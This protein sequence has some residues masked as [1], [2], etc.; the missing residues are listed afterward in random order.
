[1]CA[2]VLRGTY[3]VWPRVA[4]SLRHQVEHQEGIQ[5]RKNTAAV[6][7]NYNAAKRTPT[8]KHRLFFPGL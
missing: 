4:A 2:V 6:S 5:K 8:H 1:M 7:E 3:V